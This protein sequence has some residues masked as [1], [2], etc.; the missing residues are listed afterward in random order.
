MSASDSKPSP[1]KARQTCR[2]GGADLKAPAA[3]G[4]RRNFG[5]G[6]TPERQIGFLEALERTRS[7]TK[8][9]SSVGM[10][11]ESAHRLRNRPGGALFSA[12]WDRVFQ[13]VAPN[14]LESHERPLTDRCLARLLGPHF[15]R[16]RGDYAPLA[17][18]AGGQR[19]RGRTRTS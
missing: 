5:G 16:K 13:P 17:Q 12:L 15:R 3:P 1:T 4:R 8:A 14:R 2:D 19:G 18:M 10:S 11:R 9:A 6:W 7:V